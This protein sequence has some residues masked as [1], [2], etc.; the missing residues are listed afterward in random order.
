M[1]SIKLRIVELF[2][3]ELSDSTKQGFWLVS[4]L[5]KKH[6]LFLLLL[7][8]V[9]VFV[10]LVEGASIGLLA[11]S[12]VIITG[13]TKECLDS[14]ATASQYFPIDLCQDY[15]K[16]DMFIGVVFLSVVIQI[17][18]AI[19]VYI[20]SYLGVVLN[21]RISYEMQTKVFSHMMKLSYQEANSYSVGERQVILTIISTVLLIGLVLF[22]L[23]FLERIRK[24]GK[25]QRDL[26]ILIGR[27]AID[28]F[29]AV[30]LIKIYEKGDEV[31]DADVLLYLK[32]R[33][34]TFKK[35]YSLFLFH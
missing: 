33:Y 7:L 9:G 24:L 29:F 17:V 20:S 12:I 11:Y 34:Q 22:V 23:P 27:R 26:G 19:V 6:K 30:R 1:K 2:T 25:Q 5:V 10:G 15:N 18:K 28:Y 35:Q 31:V 3:G 13:E 32:M 8:T 14:I 21:T 16:Y 4:E